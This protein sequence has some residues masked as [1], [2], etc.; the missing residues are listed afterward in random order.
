MIAQMNVQ[1]I[2]ALRFIMLTIYLIIINNSLCII[3]LMTK[4]FGNHNKKSNYFFIMPRINY[5]KYEVF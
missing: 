4:P 3:N 5:I 1:I 2:L